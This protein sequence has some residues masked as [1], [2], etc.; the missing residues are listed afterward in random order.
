[1]KIRPSPPKGPKP[2]LRPPLPIIP[3]PIIPQ[4]VYPPT[5]FAPIRKTNRATIPKITTYVQLIL[6]IFYLR[7]S[8]PASRRGLF[9][10]LVSKYQHLIGGQGPLTQQIH[11]AQEYTFQ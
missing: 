5:R 2:Q 8:Q 11:A 3:G 9:F 10:D 1:M 6:L 4:P 7:G